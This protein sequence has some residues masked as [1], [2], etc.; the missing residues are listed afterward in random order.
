M[1]KKSSPPPEVTPEQF[2]QIPMWVDKWTK[3]AL[4]TGETDFPKA[5]KAGIEC[6]KAAG[7]APPKVVLYL[8]S[9]DA[10]VSG[11]VMA[12]HLLKLGYKPAEVKKMIEEDF[13]AT[14]KM[15]RA[16]KKLWK[17]VMESKVNLWNSYR[18][19]QLWVSWYAYVT[20]FR[21]ICGW[22][23]ELMDSFANDE[24]LCKECGWSW[25]HEEV[26][27]LCSHPRAIRRD[28]AGRLHSNNAMALEFRDGFG[29]YCHHNLPLHVEH[30]WLITNPELITPDKIE[31]E[32][33]AEIRRVM[34]EIY[35]YER[36][37]KERS[38]RVIS[39][40]K[41]VNGH[42]RRLIEVKVAGAPVRILE[43]VNGTQEPDGTYRKFFLGAMPGATPKE[44][45]AA[46]YGINPDIFEESAR[47]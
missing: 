34:L 39:T 44:C 37:L 35:G 7:L 31:A 10:C 6:Y 25:W 21:D 23:H 17:E 29:V 20:F 40:D 28:M 22:T 13:E 33:N 27:A 47:T 14:E 11:G 24:I 45:V 1:A 38:G 43:V 9:P 3:I 36:Y 30:Q 16:D 42:E 5:E 41:D 4:E 2:A 26:L 32:K 18:S 15:M 19:C 8:H 46:S 12:V